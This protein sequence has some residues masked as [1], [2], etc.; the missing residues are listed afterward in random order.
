M[1]E[2]RKLITRDEVLTLMHD[3]YEILRKARSGELTQSGTEFLNYT[4][5][6]ADVYSDL[7]GAKNI[8]EV[9]AI[10]FEYEEAEESEDEEGEE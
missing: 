2:E 9:S 8:S 1:T 6:L 10:G 5:K 7:Q 3:C 4:L